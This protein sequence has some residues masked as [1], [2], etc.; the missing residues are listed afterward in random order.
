MLDY[1]GPAA[2]LKNTKPAYRC[3]QRTSKNQGITHN[4]NTYVRLDLVDADVREKI[5]ETLLDVSWI[6]A[7]V[8]ELKKETERVMNPEEVHARIAYLQ[9][10]I[11]NLFD[12]ARYATNDSNRE[13]L[14]LMMQDLEKQQREAESLLYDIADDEEERAVLEAEIVRFEKWADKVR[15][16]LTDPFYMEHKATYEELRLAVR[17]LGIV[18]TVYPTHGDWPFRYQVVVT[19]P[20]I[21]AKVV[22]DFSEPSQP[23][24]S[25]PVSSRFL[26]P[27]VAR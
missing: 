21:L 7:K 23:L 20:E 17:I 24:A 10:E 26:G 6:R 19:A 3:Q 16:N 11:D 2:Q 13:R 15:P 27:S 18:V 8:A 14:G 9:K 4:H 5:R 25:S 22:P 12:L 1:P